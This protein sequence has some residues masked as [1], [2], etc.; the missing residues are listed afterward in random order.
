MGDLPTWS[1]SELTQCTA[2]GCTGKDEYTKYLSSSR[3]TET[4]YEYT[5]SQNIGQKYLFTDIFK[6]LEYFL[7]YM[8]G[9][10]KTPV[11]SQMIQVLKILFQF[12]FG[13]LEATCT[14]SEA[15]RLWH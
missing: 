1:V 10:Q 5:G 6:Y 7:A 12:Q 14:C 13:V 2:A 4:G 15:A 9:T 3:G 11:K 8:K